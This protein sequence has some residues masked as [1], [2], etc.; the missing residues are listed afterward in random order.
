MIK[1]IVVGKTYFMSN[2]NPPFYT[3]EIC[4]GLND[5][6]T[7]SQNG[8]KRYSTISG[9]LDHWCLTKEEAQLNMVEW[10]IKDFHG[11]DVSGKHESYQKLC[12]DILPFV[13]KE[14]PEYLI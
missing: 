10:Y 13:E 8:S 14:Y 11:R 5:D 12:K 1:N 3:S 2:G 9:A 6:G 7:Y 4:E